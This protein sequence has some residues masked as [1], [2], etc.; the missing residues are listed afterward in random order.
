MSLREIH[1]QPVACAISA[2]K[3]PSNATSTDLPAQHRD[4]Q[5][6]LIVS[7]SIRIIIN[8]L[9]LKLIVLLV[10]PDTGGDGCGEYGV[11]VTGGGGGGGNCDG[12]GGGDYDNDAGDCTGGDKWG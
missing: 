12:D 2:L 6:T 8:K 9:K 3:P 4:P 7:G 11:V 5:C 10:V 1:V